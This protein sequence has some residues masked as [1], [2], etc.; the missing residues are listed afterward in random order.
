MNS[1]FLTNP[2]EDK[3]IVGNFIKNNNH[4]GIKIEGKNGK[5]SPL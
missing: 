2:I 3:F 4:L 1:P 5:I